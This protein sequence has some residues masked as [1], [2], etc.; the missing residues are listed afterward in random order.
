[1]PCNIFGRKLTGTT[2]ANCL[3]LIFYL[4]PDCFR[5]CNL[6]HPVCTALLLGAIDV[7]VATVSKQDRQHT[8]EVYTIGFVPSYLLPDS[9]PVSLDP[10]LDALVR[11]LEDGFIEGY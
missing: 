10:F 8:A 2:T 3:S 7:Q 11:D 1:M 4:H 6:I 9:R 5:I